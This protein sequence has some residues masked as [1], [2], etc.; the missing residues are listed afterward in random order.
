MK[1]LFTILFLLY[2]ILVFA[3]KKI[4][5]KYCTKPDFVGFCL[6]FKND[7][8]FEYYWWS[9]IGHIEGKGK[10]YVNKNR[11]KL[12]FISDDTLKNSFTI[13]ENNCDTKDSV[14]LKFIIKDKESNE[15]LPF[16]YI[17][18][19]NTLK[20][21]LRKFTDTN[22]TAVFKLKKSLNEIEINVYYFSYKYFACKVKLDT[23]KE[24]I[25]CLA[26]TTYGIVEND[27]EWEYIVKKANSKKLILI[28]EDY[29]IILTKQ[30]SKN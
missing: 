9:C 22:G 26:P 27:T 20:D 16:A 19:N 11:L 17:A 30:K 18:L 25:I 7:S 28:D 6:N 15:P 8:L 3:Q 10:Y 1:Q 13:V 14:T 5:G 21:T 4:E 12:H 29:K 24:I 23:C 2:T